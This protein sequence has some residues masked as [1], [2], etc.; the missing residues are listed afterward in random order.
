[1][2]LH[3]ALGFGPSVRRCVGEW[4]NARLCFSCLLSSLCIN[5]TRMY[6]MNR[7]KHRNVQLELKTS[8]MLQALQYYQTR[9]Y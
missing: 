3:E 5:T 7:S 6:A 9:V 8:R 4:E 2:L 1:M